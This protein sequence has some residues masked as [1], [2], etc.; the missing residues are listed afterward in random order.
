ME[1]LPILLIHFFALLIPG[2]DFFI[3][4]SYA[5][6]TNF[7]KALSVVFGISF[8]LLIWIVVSLS[9]LKILFEMYP[10]MRFVLIFLGVFY[11][12]YL[13][14]LLLK[15]L[16]Q[17]E[18]IAKFKKPKKAFIDG[19]ITNITNAKVLFYF[20]SIFSSLKFSHDFF[21]L[22]CLVV[23]L[24][25]E[26]FIYFSLIAVLFSNVKMKEIYFK[27]YKKLDF[28]CAIFFIIFAIWMIKNAYVDFASP[29]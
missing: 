11:L 1:F 26:S 22:G 21:Q 13:A 3:V 24:V 12:T 4:S 7:K 17:K 25:L 6:K 27:H 18:D 10:L 15:N 2:P 28:L 9:G 14:F 19:F 20:S 29:Q 23:F 16:K 8:G 5:L